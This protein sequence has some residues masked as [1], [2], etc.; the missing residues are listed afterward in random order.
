MHMPM[1]YCPMPKE[2]VCF[3]AMVS[4]RTIINAPSGR[5]TCTVYARAGV[6]SDDG[7]LC[8]QYSQERVATKEI[9]KLV[10]TR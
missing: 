2:R 1:Q 7:S 8:D 5:R 10:R 6:S 4:Q 3:T 9:R